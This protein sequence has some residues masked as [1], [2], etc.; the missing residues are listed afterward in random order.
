[1]NTQISIIGCGWLGLPLAE[2]LI[3]K[4][5]TIKGSTTSPS[6]L[7]HLKSCGIHPYRIQLN[8][9][10]IIGDIS[11]FLAGSDIVIIN[12]PP[13]LRKNPNKNHIKEIELLVKHI[14]AQQVKHVLYISSTSV[15]KN[16]DHIPLI[17]HDTLPNATS[18]SGQQLIT[19]EEMLKQNPNFKTT[20]LR[21][22]GLLD[23][24]R[25]PGKTLSGK[26]ELKNGD[27]P[28]NL[29]HKEDCV[30]IIG[31]LIQHNIWD[32][33]FNASNP[34]HP[35]KKEYYTTYCKTNQLPL[36]QFDLQSKSLGK[37]IDSSKLVQLLNYRFKVDL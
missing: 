4:K 26:T 30:Q 31:E 16:E 27:A 37:L 15:F 18:N 11:S 34:S 2:H 33:T 20:I 13:G 14:E 8:S 10:E 23:T 25:H 21:F 6:K 29:I 17:T 24:K 9:E 12:I 19:I 1:M 5:C 32:A 28:V 7:E 3:K 36:P 22:S 35:I